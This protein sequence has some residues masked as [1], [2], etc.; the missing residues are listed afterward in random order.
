[1]SAASPK[2]K[3]TK[4]SPSPT[5][6]V[7]SV[8]G[9][10]TGAFARVLAETRAAGLAIERFEITEDLVLEPPT[11]TQ[12]DLVEQYSAAYLLAQSSALNLLRSQPPAPEDHEE[13]ATWAQQQQEALNNAYTIAKEAERKFNEALYGGPEMLQRVE[14]F[15]TGRPG[16]EKQAFASAVNQQF[17]RLPKDGCCAA[18]GQVVDEQAGESDGESSGGSSTSGTSS[19]VT[20]PTPESSEGS[21]PA[22]GSEEPGPGPSSSTTPNSLP[23]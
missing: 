15:F 5:P 19:N 4:G 11:E 16:W 1:M 8:G 3:A 17:R 21:T 10:P 23:E 6:R 18:C 12:M 22:T 2:K 7:V 9:E 13:R 20:S 14:E